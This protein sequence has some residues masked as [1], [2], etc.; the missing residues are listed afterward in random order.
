ME[1]DEDEEDN[2]NNGL[3]EEDPQIQ[4]IKERIRLFKQ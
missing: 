3:E 1:G 4:K 2:F